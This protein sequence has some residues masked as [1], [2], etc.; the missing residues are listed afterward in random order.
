MQAEGIV[1]DIIFTNEENGYTVCAVEKDDDSF[2]AVGNMPGLMPGEAV[3]L[4][5][6][7]TSHAEYGEQFKVA[8]Y[9]TV[10][11]ATAVRILMYLSAGIVKGIGPATAKKIVDRFG[12]KSLEIIQNEPLK[13]ASIKGISKKKALEINESYL[14]KQIMQNIIMFLQPYGVT[15]AFAVRVY[16][17]M[18]AEAV[19]KIKQNPYSLCEIDGI[20]FKTADK[21][22]FQMG[23]SPDDEER[24]RWGVLYV[25]TLSS[26]NGDTY[27][28][29]LTLLKNACHILS[30]GTEQVENAIVSLIKDGKLTEEVT[31][32]ASAVYLP[33]FYNA[34]LGTAR[35]LSSMLVK[36]PISYDGDFEAMM[37]KV[38]NDTQITLSEKQR[39]ACRVACEYSA[40][41]ITGG[42]GTGKTTVINSVIAFMEMAGLTVTLCAPTGR[43]AKRL[44]EMCGREAKTIHRLLELTFSEGER[45]YFS[46]DESFPLDED[47]II[48]DEMSMVDILL[49]NS[50]LKA[51][52]PGGR[53]IMSGDADQLPSV[54]AG[55]VLRDMIDSKRIPT[56]RLDEI[57]RQAAESMIIVNAHKINRGEEPILN[58]QDKDFFMMDRLNA[59]DIMDTVCALCAKR[60]PAAYGLS[61][62]ADIQVITPPRRTP[63]GVYELNKRLQAVLNPP[64]KG[65][66]EKAFELGIL[67][68]GDKVMQIK[69]DYSIEWQNID[70][71]DEGEGAFNGDIGTVEE[72][73]LRSRT[74]KVIFDDR[75]VEY[76]FSQVDELELAYAVTVHKSQGSEF[77]AVIMPLY[78]M[79]PMLANRNLLYTALTRAKELVVLVGRRD[80][81]AKM[82]KNHNEVMRNS[83]LKYRLEKIITNN[84]GIIK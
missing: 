34:E 14:S 7:W 79:P 32:D 55:C 82:V 75:R 20:G 24:L 41:V 35:R 51:I 50:L 68:E 13:L 11:P 37:D 44:G 47:V 40:A 27:S 33:Y 16:N 58:V 17:K 71:G 73:D 19:R 72:I 63:L 36:Q 48:V 61:P 83:L 46:R 43:A 76:D 4:T 66:T 8:S 69:N 53:I 54:G 45:Q 64:Q 65:K 31:D 28:E 10:V 84:F 59:E 52:K 38:E 80:V 21:I 39:L 23:I 9:E 42:P 81:L 60:L 18:G 67:R 74:V 22:A 12:D 1:S 30:A 77:P 78:P 70:T 56:V 6:E 49:M 2:V 26:Q 29:Y 15:P 57:Y 3:I 62:F 25:M 5:G